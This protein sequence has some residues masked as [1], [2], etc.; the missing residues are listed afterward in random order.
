MYVAPPPT[1]TVTHTHTHTPP[2]HSRG[3][4]FLSIFP[5]DREWYFFDMLFSCQK[6]RKRPESVCMLLFLPSRDEKFMF[7][8]LFC[9]FCGE[10]SQTFRI[11]REKSFR[12]ARSPWGRG[13]LSKIDVPCILSDVAL[14]RVCKGVH[15]FSPMMYPHASTQMGEKVRLCNSSKT[16]V[17]S[18]INKRNDTHTHTHTHTQ[19]AQSHT[20]T[21][22]NTYT[23]THMHTYTHAHTH[24]HTY[25]HTQI[26]T[27][28][29]IY[30][31][32]H[33]YTHIHTYTRTHIHTYTHAHTHARTH[34]HT[35]LLFF[36]CSIVYKFVEFF[37]LL[38]PTRI[39]LSKRLRSFIARHRKIR[40]KKYWNTLTE[41]FFKVKMI[42]IFPNV[43]ELP[44]K[45]WR[46][47]EALLNDTF[48]VKKCHKVHQIMFEIFPAINFV[49]RI[50]FWK[51]LSVLPH[52]VAISPWV[53][54][55]RYFAHEKMKN[56]RKFI[57]FLKNSRN[58]LLM[59]T[60]SS[61]T[62]STIAAVFNHFPA[63]TSYRKRGMYYFSSHRMGVAKFWVHIFEK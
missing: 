16:M 58:A 51:F 39:N 23:H 61:E 15:R 48:F 41:W 59:S 6:H 18:H 47:S 54:K 57:F 43:L 4:V 11:L 5:S 49:R 40:T 26:H 36:C 1:H 3:G 42:M 24:I 46:I 19:H 13:V 45:M 7:L 52:K 22:K 2:P 27:H 62:Y 21:H 25:T 60:A 12:Y 53:V 10:N 63:C 30:T 29:H 9:N 37:L 44:F 32:T 8:S 28:T 17:F 33:T 31:Y 34:T 56:P 50:H 14:P 35:H 38:R 20:H 55:D